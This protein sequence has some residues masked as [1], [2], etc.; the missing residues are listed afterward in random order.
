MANLEIWIAWNED[1]TY[2]ADVDCAADAS[3]EL[4]DDEGGAVIGVVKLNVTVPDLTVPETDI[5]I[6]EKDVSVAV[7]VE[8]AQ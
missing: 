1:G 2:R 7:Q 4:I 6:E 5:T 3:Q 8:A